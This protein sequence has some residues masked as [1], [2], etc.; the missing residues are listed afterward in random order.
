[1]HQLR[2]KWKA[3]TRP[4]LFPSLFPGQISVETEL[5][6]RN[7]WRL[8]RGPFWLE[9]HQS[10][11]PNCL[12]H[13]CAR[14][15]SHEHTVYW[16]CSLAAAR[17]VWDYLKYL[18]RQAHC[19]ANNKCPE[20]WALADFKTSVPNCKPVVSHTTSFQLQ[21]KKCL[22]HSVEVSSSVCVLTLRCERYAISNSFLCRWHRLTSL[23]LH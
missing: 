15:H 22:A 17:R 4:G 6:I 3:L 12:T 2:W 19:Y 18:G 11:I 9:G 13:T 14:T 1:M 21:K 8:I 20:P 16:K 10:V 23:W 7:A 5:P